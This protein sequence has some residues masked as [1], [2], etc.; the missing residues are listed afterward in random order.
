MVIRHLFGSAFAG[1]ALIDKAISADSLYYGQNDA[2][3][4][5][6]QNIDALNTVI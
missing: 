4:L 6:A 2:A 1:D 3:T 5:V